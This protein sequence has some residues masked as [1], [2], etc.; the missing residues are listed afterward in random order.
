MKV[1]IEILVKN[2]GEEVADITADEWKQL[3]G[4]RQS[5][6]ELGE[7]DFRDAMF[8]QIK[9]FREKSEGRKLMLLWK[10][11]TESE[12]PD[13][14]S[15]MH[16]YP[17]DVLF[18]SPS[19]AQMVLDTIRGLAGM[20]VDKIKD[21]YK[22]LKKAKLHSE[23]SQKSVFLERNLPKRYAKLNIRAE[24]LAAYFASKLGASPNTWCNNPMREDVVMDFVK[25]NYDASFRPDIESKIKKMTSD[26]AKA[27]LLKLI[28]SIPD[29]GIALMS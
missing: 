9:A 17:A 23:N 19:D 8:T 20:S 13:H 14:W 24:D 25:S 27:E 28:A 21:A 18:A 7:V 1:P 5:G 22:V 10:E 4:A 2:L 29:A 16:T 3:L 12:D 26:E 15:S 11:K 6:A